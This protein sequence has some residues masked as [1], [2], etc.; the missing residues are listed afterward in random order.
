MNSPP[1]R[2]CR[3]KSRSR[4]SVSEADSGAEAAGLSWIPTEYTRFASK[5]DMIDRCERGQGE[6]YSRVPRL[7]VHVTSGYRVPPHTASTY[8]ALVVK[9]CVRWMNFNAQIGKDIKY[10]G[11]TNA[12]ENTEYFRPQFMSD[13]GD[14]RRHRGLAFYLAQA[15]QQ[16]LC[17]SI[18]ACYLACLAPL[19]HLTFYHTPLRQDVHPLRGLLSVRGSG[20]AT[21]PIAQSTT[22][23]PHC[24][25]KHWTKRGVRVSK[26]CAKVLG[27]YPSEWGGRH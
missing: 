23:P 21:R 6:C 9:Y 25:R 19:E 10:E 14:A 1:T 17:L 27:L 5:P 24:C 11:Y 16:C 15:L 7:H 2:Y 26:T 20:D 12:S 4:L 3:R 22:R 8:N 13:C 18:P